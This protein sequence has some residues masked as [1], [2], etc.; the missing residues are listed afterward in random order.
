MCA[1]RTLH[2]PPPPPSPAMPPAG[3]V[4]QVREGLRVDP[5]I[6]VAPRVALLASVSSAPG[7]ALL[8]DC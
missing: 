3:I 2:P 8:L 5:I 1:A 7:R 6:P 4:L